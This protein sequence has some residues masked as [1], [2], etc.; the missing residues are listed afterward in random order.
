MEGDKTMRKLLITGLS[1]ALC[2]S[3]AVAAS[4]GN[5]SKNSKKNLYIQEIMID[6]AETCDTNNGGTI[7]ITGLNFDKG[8]PL[9]VTLAG[10]PITVCDTDFTGAKTVIFAE[11]PT[12]L[13]AGDYRVTVSTGPAVKD[14]DEYDLT[15]GADGTGCCP[16]DRI[17]D[18]K[19]LSLEPLEN[20]NSFQV[21]CRPSHPNL[22]TG[23][24]IIGLRDSDPAQNVFIWKAEPKDKET[25][26]CDW[27]ELGARNY[28]TLDRVDISV[29][30]ICEAN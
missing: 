4:A 30:V 28:N 25:G 23:G 27:F 1:I 2:L 22:V 19:I 14:F 3:L 29:R 16:V 12:G 21:F 17:T 18:F 26:C 13:I 24:Y 9:T 15:I 11:L 6:P 20:Q 8:A 7:K 5:K 10:D